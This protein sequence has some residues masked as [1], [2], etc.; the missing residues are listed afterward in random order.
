M[1]KDKN[2]KVKMT[3]IGDRLIVRQDKAPTES[4]GGIHLPR[5]TNELEKPNTGEV[6]A[7]GPGKLLDDGSRGE[8]EA[9]VGDVVVFPK[10]GGQIIGGDDGSDL[11]AFHMPDII[12]ITNK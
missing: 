11:V 10:F 4:A 1:T 3:P 8:M 5:S 7:I 6:L 12:A 2:D 9:E